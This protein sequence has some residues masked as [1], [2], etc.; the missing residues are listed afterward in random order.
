MSTY[1]YR[2]PG[3]AGE[4]ITLTID[5]HIARRIRELHGQSSIGDQTGDRTSV[6]KW[7]VEIIESFLSDRRSG[8]VPRE[9][10]RFW[11]QNTEHC[12]WEEA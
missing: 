3:K 7:C 2:N 12:T 8:I 4:P 10:D 11:N 6:E 9:R 1:P 5:G